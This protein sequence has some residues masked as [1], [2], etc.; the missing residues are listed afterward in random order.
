[1]TDG[2]N[3]EALGKT[4]GTSAL[5]ALSGDFE[6]AGSLLTN[7]D[8]YTGEGYDEIERKKEELARRK[9][10]LERQQALRLQ[11]LEACQKR[12][13]AYKAADIQRT[14]RRENKIQEMYDSYSAQYDQDRAD[15]LAENRS[16]YNAQKAEYDAQRD[17]LIE[18]YSA[19][20]T[21]IA[22]YCATEEDTPIGHGF[23]VQ[24]R[25]LDMTVYMTKTKR[26]SY[27]L[28][29][30]VANFVWANIFD[31][32]KVTKDSCEEADCLHRC[33]GTAM[34]SHCAV[35]YDQILKYA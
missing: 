9:A 26:F 18:R 25:G 1:M 6:A 28:G 12:L 4:L 8:L 32:T 22:D 20:A 16:S 5:L 33:H 23:P 19:R 13:A 15:I 29:E 14:Q 21:Q 3:W 10:E 7:E 2:D 35:C 34:T 31:S 24:I 11:Y 30:R 17:P 27:L